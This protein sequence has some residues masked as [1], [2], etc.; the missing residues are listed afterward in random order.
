MA[1]QRI[2]IMGI[3]AL[4]TAGCSA[5]TVTVENYV[6]IKSQYCSAIMDDLPGEL[7][8][9]GKRKMTQNPVSSLVAA[10]GDPTIVVKCGVT[11]PFN[12]QLETDLLTINEIDWRY[13]QSES[14]TRF[15]SESLRTIVEVDVPS[16]YGNPTDA[17]VDLTEAL[18]QIKN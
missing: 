16:D 5:P 17:L 12:A 10:W 1:L 11:V 2:S 14:G 13:E 3:A 4:L 8:S 7:L 18:A 15:F 6:P 9:Q